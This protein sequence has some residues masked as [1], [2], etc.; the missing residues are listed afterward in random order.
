M[1]RRV[2]VKVI[3]RIAPFDYAPRGGA[4][5]RLLARLLAGKDGALAGCRFQIVKGPALGLPGSPRGGHPGLPGGSGLGR[6]VADR[7]PG[8]RGCGGARP[9]GRDQPLPGTSGD[10]PAARGPAGKPVAVARRASDRST[11]CRFRPATQRHSAFPCDCLA[12]FLDIAL[13]RPHECLSCLTMAAVRL[14]AFEKAERPHQA[15]R[16][17]EFVRG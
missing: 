14:A 7:G 17:K 3:G 10:R 2:L 4:V 1:Q 8:T 5:Q 15:R 9:G 13:N 16:S 11:A 6:D 12:S